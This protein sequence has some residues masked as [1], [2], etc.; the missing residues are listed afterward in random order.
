M[1]MWDVLA[2]SG[3]SDEDDSRSATP[4][5][6]IRAS[7]SVDLMYTAEDVVNGLQNDVMD[8]VDLP[9]M[10]RTP[11]SDK[12][13]RKKKKKEKMMRRRARNLHNSFAGLMDSSGGGPGN[14][15]DSGDSDDESEFSSDRSTSTPPPSSSSSSRRE[16]V[17]NASQPYR[18]DLSVNCVY[19]LTAQVFD[20]V[21][22]CEDHRSAFDSWADAVLRDSSFVDIADVINQFMVHLNSAVESGN[23][24]QAPKSPFDEWVAQ[25]K[26]RRNKAKSVAQNTLVVYNG[27]KERVS[28]TN[29]AAISG[30]VDDSMK[31]GL[32]FALKSDCNNCCACSNASLPSKTRRPGTHE[33]VT[34]TSFAFLGAYMRHRLLFLLRQP[35]K[36]LCRKPLGPARK[37]KQKNSQKYQKVA[38]SRKNRRSKQQ[39]CSQE[40]G[41][42]ESGQSQD[43]SELQQPRSSGLSDD[44]ATGPSPISVKSTGGS[45]A[46]STNSVGSQDEMETDMWG[47]SF[48]DAGAPPTSAEQSVILAASARVRTVHTCA[49]CMEVLCH[50]CSLRRCGH[51]FCRG[52][53]LSMLYAAARVRQLTDLLRV[54]AHWFGLSFVLCA[55]GQLLAVPCR[56]QSLTTFPHSV[57][58]AGR[59]SERPTSFQITSW[60]TSLGKLIR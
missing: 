44:S 14:D 8:Y 5:N 19:L 13:R 17:S 31:H 6:G 30:R 60:I 39:R 37:L 11:P 48:K 1:S 34:T 52:C 25:E 27:S 24:C 29:D 7:V 40:S 28:I 57:R 51:V 3:S 35:L 22:F 36:K 55:Y 26:Q 20:D 21:Q 53:L 38:V 23:D 49:V 47:C 4:A 54:P 41:S 42:Q 33:A 56:R 59:T 32:T 50:P 58:C 2:S 45:D 46:A 43:E 10:M 16:R 15:A 9:L 18:H 12:F